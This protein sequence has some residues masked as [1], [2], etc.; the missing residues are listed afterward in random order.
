MEKHKLAMLAIQVVVYYLITLGGLFA[1][2][3]SYPE[4]R[5]YLPVGGID[6]LNLE[7]NLIPM[8]ESGALD[9]RAVEDRALRLLMSL[10]GTLVFMVPVSLVYASTR[11]G[12]QTGAMLETIFLLPIVVT[13]VIVIVQNSLVLAFSLFGVV[14]AVRF[15]NSLKS[16]SDAVFVF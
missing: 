7:Q 15:R 9:T 2:L 16:P 11:S 6:R 10:V 14:G 5:D 4:A 1:L 12:K 8:T 3:Y 13:S